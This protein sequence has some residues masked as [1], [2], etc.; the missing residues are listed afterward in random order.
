MA[1]E[2]QFEIYKED[3]EFNYE[4][5]AELDF[6]EYSNDND[7]NDCDDRKVRPEANYLCDQRSGDK[8]VDEDEII[9]KFN[10][11][12]RNFK[13]NRTS[14]VCE[15]QNPKC[16]GLMFDFDIY[17]KDA[18]PQFDDID[19]KNIAH[20]LIKHIAQLLDVQAVDKKQSNYADYFYI[21]EIRKP[22][23]K[24]NEL[25]F[26]N[27]KQLYKD[28]VHYIIPQIQL[29]RDAKKYIISSLKQN[30]IFKS[31][32]EQYAIERM[33]DFLD[34]NSSWTPV[35]LIGSCKR[36][37]NVFYPL[38]V[39]YKYS[40][41][42]G[43]LNVAKNLI[44][45]NDNIPLEFAIHKWG[46]ETKI[47]NKRQFE[48]N[49]DA[50]IECIKYIDEL[51]EIKNHKEQKRNEN[52]DKYKPNDKTIEKVKQNKKQFTELLKE[53]CITMNEK[54]AR[55]GKN[56]RSILAVLKN[57]Q[58][59]FELDGDEVIDI[60]DKFSRLCPDAYK[61]RRD[62]ERHYENI[63][64][65]GQYGLL[66]YFLKQDGIEFK[67]L[68]NKYSQ[69]VSSDE[70]ANNDTQVK[71]KNSFDNTDFTFHSFMKQYKDKT[72]ETLAILKSTMYNECPKVINMAIQGKGIYIK[73]T[74]KYPELITSLG[75]ND[76]TMYYKIV[77]EKTNI[78][79]TESIKLSKYLDNS[80]EKYER[81]D[82]DLGDCPEYVFNL[83]SG[84]QAQAIG[85][86]N[87]SSCE[88]MKDFIKTIWASNN[89]EY[90]NYIISWIAGL[91]QKGNDINKTALVM[92]SEQG[93]GKD[94]LVDFLEYVLGEACILRE[95]GIS[96]ITQKHN[97]H[98][99]GKRLVIINEMSSVREE[100]RSNFDKI[101]PYITENRIT[102]EPKC[103]EK[104]DVRNIGNYMLFTNHKDSVVIEESD[105]RYAVFEVSKVHRNDEKYFSEIRKQC[106]NQQTANDFFTYLTNYKP[107]SLFKMPITELKTDIMELSKPT[108]RKFL[109]EYVV[110]VPDDEKVISASLLY[111]NYSAWCNQNGERNIMTNTKFG[112]C[113][114]NVV[115]KTKTRTGAMYDLN[116]YKR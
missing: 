59:T 88:M 29:N 30:E 69:Y 107:Q 36:D 55:D 92:S 95:N 70:V 47:T 81:V 61:N 74:S 34:I 113:V 102:I 43:N 60:A 20:E 101:K 83:W 82:C 109:D 87:S 66:I 110:N 17:Q 54:R 105:R 97:G 115:E 116:T 52:N 108:W 16:S 98:L 37:R 103:M 106:F 80:C 38:N 94:T 28:G 49:K 93:C 6:D 73:K 25:N 9:N 65:Y 79:K 68:I 35:L 14:H 18:K 56:W 75:M 11:L 40:V 10:E 62:V 57:I 23:K 76:F 50:Q 5:D 21:A 96:N 72:F 41:K 78:S 42:T 89:Q 13:S 39:I 53:T 51:N 104:Y 58:E 46:Y 99:V 32:T 90:Y 112:T 45:N 77:D 27:E 22:V 2:I 48:L 4:S 8:F 24:H 31:I 15:I 91:I 7:C 3:R 111:S 1:K 84:F 64:P 44:D 100:F 19:F 12:G 63:K 33:D 71:S 114:K 67:N 26:S 85:D 86:E